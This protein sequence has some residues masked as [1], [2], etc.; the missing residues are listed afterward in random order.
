MALARP[1]RMATMEHMGSWSKLWIFEERWKKH[2]IFEVSATAPDENKVK[3]R[4]PFEIDEA[5]YSSFKKLLRVT[6]Y[7]NRFI[8]YMKNK[9]KI[10]NQLTANEINIAELVWIKYI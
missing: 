1:K 6:A 4:K 3:V 10:D 7:V 8:N 5:R 9:R 2:V